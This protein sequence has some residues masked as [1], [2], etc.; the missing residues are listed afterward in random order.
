MKLGIYVQAGEIKTSVDFG[1]IESKMA[2]RQPSCISQKNP[3]PIFCNSDRIDLKLG[4]Y[5]QAG[6][7]KIPIEN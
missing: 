1:Q 4:M 2:A 7:A 3:D 5:V 6:E